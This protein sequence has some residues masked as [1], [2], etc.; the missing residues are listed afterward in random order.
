M[1]MHLKR[2]HYSLILCLN[3]SPLVPRRWK[4]SIVQSLLHDLHLRQQVEFT[5]KDVNLAQKCDFFRNHC[6]MVCQFMTTIEIL[7][8]M[9]L[10]VKT[11]INS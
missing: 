1:I 9:P 2:N 4:V 10:K 7:Y 5:E 3:Q 11:K 6:L 8:D